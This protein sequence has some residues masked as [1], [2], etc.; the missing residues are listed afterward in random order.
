MF[1][2]EPGLLLNLY[3]TAYCELTVDK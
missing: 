2:L 1:D 3:K